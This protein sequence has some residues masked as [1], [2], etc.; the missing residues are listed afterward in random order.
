[1]TASNANFKVNGI[2][3]TKTSNTITDVIEGVALNL[4]KVTTSPVT[5]TVARD[6]STV[7][8]SIAGFVKA[9][10]DIVATLKSSSGYD[11][12]TKQGGIL[13]GDSTVRN[14]QNQLRNMLNTE[15]TGASGSLTRLAD[16]GVNFQKDGHAGCQP[17]QAQ[18][19]NQQPFQ[20]Y[21]QPV[22]LVARHRTA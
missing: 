17:D 1:M 15:V 13:L 19:C 5:L 22:R 9:Y 11:A 18:R 16:V 21:R 7:S 12:A 8:N 10:N 14:L 20:R 2:A 6:T 4:S 3:I